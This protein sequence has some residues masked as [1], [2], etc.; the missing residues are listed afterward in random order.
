MANSTG[1]IGLARNAW[2]QH[3]MVGALSMLGRHEHDPISPEARLARSVVNL[4]LVAP[5]PI[6]PRLVSLTRSPRPLSLALLP[7]VYDLGAILG[8]IRLHRRL[9][10]ALR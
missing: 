1:L 7:S 10:S 8:V 6:G 2:A 3:G 9:A 4:K 5:S